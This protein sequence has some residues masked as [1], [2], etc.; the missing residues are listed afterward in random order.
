MKKVTIGKK[1]YE[2][3]IKEG[4]SYIDGQTVDKFIKKLSKDDILR[5][6]K[7]GRIVIDDERKGVT[8]PPM[9]YQFY[10]ME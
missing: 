3:E 2:V 6:A 9:K 7:V 8:P 10:S 4:I 5:M 1:E